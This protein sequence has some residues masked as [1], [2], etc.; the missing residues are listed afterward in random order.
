MSLFAGNELPTMTDSEYRMLSEFVRKHCGLHFGPESRFLLEKRV[1]RRVR[2]LELT[3]FS[4]YHYLLRSGASSA[5]YFLDRLVS[6]R[7]G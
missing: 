2:D 4:A 1:A 7:D 3:S 6:R 5:G